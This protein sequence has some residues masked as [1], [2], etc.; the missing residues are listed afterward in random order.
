MGFKGV[1]K[2]FSLTHKNTKKKN[3]HGQ[4]YHSYAILEGVIGEM[5]NKISEIPTTDNITS[6]LSDDEC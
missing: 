2:T 3:H 5:K 4:A 1:L 6:N